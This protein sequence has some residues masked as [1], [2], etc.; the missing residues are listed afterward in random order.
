MKK[1]KRILSFFIVVALVFTMALGNV[2]VSA[3][4]PKLSKTKVTLLKGE[5]ITLKVTGTKKKVTWSSSKKNIATVTSKG[6]VLAKKKGS[7]TITAKVNKKSY[8]CVVKV[9]DPK[10]SKT[11]LTLTEKK[12]SSIKLNG[13]TVKVTYVSSNPKI[14]RVNSR[15]KITAVKKGS[16]VITVKANTKKF[17]CKVT[18]KTAPKP[19]PTVTPK[20]TATP[21]PTEAPKP[22]LSAT[23][24]TMNKGTVKQ[25]QVKNYKEILVWTSD[26]PSVATVDSKGKVTAV[27]LGTTKIRVRDKSTWRGSCTVHVTQTV[28]KQVEP[29]LK[30][31]TKSAKKEITNNK[32]QKEVIDVT[33]NTYTYTFTTIPTNAAE[34]K[35]YDITTSD[36][37]YKTMAL[38][39]LAYRTWTPTNPTDCEEMLSYLNNKEMTQYYKN[40][41]RDRMKADNGYKYLGNSY[42]NGATPANN[43]TPSKPISITLRQDTLPGKGNSISENIPYFEPTQTTPAIYRSFT[44]FAGSD[45]SRW[46]CTYKHSKTGKWYIWDQSWH[47]L[48][49]RIKQPAGKYE[50]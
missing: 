29:V 18:V 13:T 37:R 46:I 4:A 25:L 5:K 32:G 48:L 7:A 17:K 40:F 27:N 19:K 49:T 22:S 47:D 10:L 39:I 44:D 50:Y 24:L 16:A 30:K 26:D 8:K 9:E 33:I 43:Y 3:A 1:K 6:Q 15:G 34:L 12:T 41:L 36:G 20:P 23:T 11:S 14:V 45:S 21:K 35:Q 2:S 31:G 38:L 42:L 28:K